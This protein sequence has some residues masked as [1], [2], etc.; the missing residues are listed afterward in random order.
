RDWSSDV[1]SSDLV[2]AKTFGVLHDLCPQFLFR[3]IKVAVQ[4]F[5]TAVFCT[6]NA[7]A[8]FIRQIKKVDLSRVHLGLKT[9]SLQTFRRR[10]NR[11]KTMLLKNIL[12][13]NRC[14]NAFQV[15]V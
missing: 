3:K 2:W 7:L 8:K 6:H 9:Q 14:K 1:C 12:R 13:D 10:F 11:L 15:Y 5:E 4:Y